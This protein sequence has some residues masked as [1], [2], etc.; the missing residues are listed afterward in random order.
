M[1]D[2]Y[3]FYIDGYRR[4][5]SQQL[6]SKIT[7]TRGSGLHSGGCLC[8]EGSRKRKS[9]ILKVCCCRCKKQQTG[10]MKVEIELSGKILA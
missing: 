1:I 8:F 5:N 3:F 6:I 4:V 7:T 10:S 9:D 2:T